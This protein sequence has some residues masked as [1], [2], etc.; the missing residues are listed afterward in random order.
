V[1]LLLLLLLLLVTTHS[2][3]GVVVP[4]L[5]QLATQHP[6]LTHSCICHDVVLFCSL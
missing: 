2:A 4:C 3:T 6:L 5:N 1:L